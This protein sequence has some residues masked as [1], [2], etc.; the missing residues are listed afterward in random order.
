M[1]LVDT[2]VFVYAA[3]QGCPEH[4][5]CQE[6]LDEWR[7]Q[8]S[9]WFTTWP[10]LYEFLRVATH[11][12]A[13]R[14]PWNAAEAWDYLEG[15]L[16]VPSLHVLVETERHA[17]VAALTLKEIPAL[18]GSVMHDAHTAILMREHGLSSIITRDNGFHRFPFLEVIDPLAGQ[19]GG[20]ES[21]GGLSVREGVGSHGRAHGRV[22]ASPRAGRSRRSP[23]P[24]RRGR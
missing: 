20:G 15:L 24:S 3:H 18:R 11:P 21:M 8:P 4:E 10:I 14:N 19:Y 23:S 1:F 22:Q 13:S 5:R 12:R 7:R 17:E 6:L 2:N 16:S 9:S